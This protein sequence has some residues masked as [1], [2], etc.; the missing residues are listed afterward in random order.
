MLGWA[1]AVVPS[2]LTEYLLCSANIPRLHSYAGLR[3]SFIQA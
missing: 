2:S 1:I 3:V